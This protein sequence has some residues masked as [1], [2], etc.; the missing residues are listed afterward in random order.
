MLDLSTYLVRE[1]VGMFKFSNTYDILD[2][3]NGSQVGIAKE[4]VSGLV[5][6]LRLLINKQFLP[7]KVDVHQGNSFENQDNLVFSIR[8]GFTLF[9]PRVE[10]YDAQGTC[11]GWLIVKVFSIGR[12]FMIHDAN[13]TQVGLVKGNWVGWDFRILDQQER[14]LGR[15]TKKWSGLG[16]ELFTTA[17]TYVVDLG[18]NPGAGKAMLFLAAGLAI[19]TVFKEK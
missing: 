9:K 15:I 13:G 3:R 6:L 10:I 2:A 11:V 17:D 18:S 7:T 8:R 14:E 4:K 16:K 12:T 5:Q 1:H 19:D